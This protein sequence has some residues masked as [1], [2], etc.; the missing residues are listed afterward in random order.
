M[1][2]PTIQTRP[3]GRVLL[4][5][6]RGPW[7]GADIA[8]TAPAVAVVLTPASATYQI[9]SPSAD[10]NVTL[11]S[12]VT[13]SGMD[14]VIR[15]NSPT[16]N[17]LTVLRAAVD[18]GGTLAFVAPGEELFV[19][20]TGTVANNWQ[21]IQRTPGAENVNDATMAGALVL[22]A[23]EPLRRRH[24]RMDPDGADRLL[25]L[26]LSDTNPGQW[27]TI[28]NTG[29]NG[30]ILTL[31]SDA[32][33]PNPDRFLNPG[34]E[35]TVVSVP[36][37]GYLTAIETRAINEH[38]EI[39]AA[40]AFT[41]AGSQIDL[42][43]FQVAA[44]EGG[45]PQTPTVRVVTLPAPAG[46]GG[47]SYLIRNNSATFSSVLDIQTSAAVSLVQIAPQEIARVTQFAGEFV[48][49]DVWR[50]P[51]MALQTPLAGAKT[52]VPG[53]PTYQFLDPGGASRVLTLPISTACPGK[54]FV[55]KNIADGAGELL[56]VT[57]DGG[58]GGGV[59]ATLWPGD[60]IELV[61]SVIAGGGLNQGF[62]RASSGADIMGFEAITPLGGGAD[63]DLTD[64]NARL[65]I[66]THDNAAGAGVVRM[67]AIGA[68]NRG[69]LFVFR[70][71]VGDAAG[72]D[73][74]IRSTVA[75][76]D[77]LI[78]DVEQAIVGV[79]GVRTVIIFN[80]GAAWRSFGQMTST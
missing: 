56:T 5:G 8:I 35:L 46:M 31:R 28:L 4:S 23:T 68:F 55:V 54:R 1:V 25:T 27:F 70:V 12:A 32:G 72:E 74:V 13:A 62:Q 3:D 80:D 26:P 40:G 19:K 44:D 29:D 41:I 57:A 10:I 75:D 22:N 65:F 2:A 69:K 61:S 38:Q 9:M 21:V 7:A 77:V 60:Q 18:G 34:D 20:S 17:V 78:E 58:D 33:D 24:Q 47:K 53:S 71:V 66:A 16:A 30:E 50:N 15:N 63:I 76:G 59:L 79:N 36:V 48:L 45:A 42:E 52:L 37:A 73:V 49:S 11:P 64:A 43:V 39:S 67:P 6:D 14:L 51:S